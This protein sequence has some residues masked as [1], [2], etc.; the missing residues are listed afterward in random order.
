MRFSSTRIIIFLN[1]ILVCIVSYLFG[2]MTSSWLHERVLPLGFSTITDFKIDKKNLV[3]DAGKSQ[4]EF[5]IILDRNIFN[6]QKTQERK[7][8][9]FKK[10]PSPR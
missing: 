10:R 4:K 8:S 2:G 7:V 3:L 1:F 5:A 6:A 9:I